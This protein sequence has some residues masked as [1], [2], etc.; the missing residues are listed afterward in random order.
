MSRRSM[1]TNGTRRLVRTTLWSA[2]GGVSLG[3]FCAGAVADETPEQVVVQFADLDLTSP[4]DAKTL[5]S[6]LQRASRYVC[7]EFESREPAK[8]RLRQQCYDE[9]L[10]AAVQSVNHTVLSAMHEDKRIRLAGVGKRRM[11][12]G[13]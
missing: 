13:G 5:Y 8:A 11:A 7:R 1:L 12:E 6:R 2:L 9:A 4:Q 3:L 10:A